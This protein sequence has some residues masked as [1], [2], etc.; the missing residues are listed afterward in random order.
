MKVIFKDKERLLLGKNITLNDEIKFT[1]IDINFNEVDFSK[2][3]NITIFSIFP[4]INTKVCDLQTTSMNKTALL[5]PAFDFIAISLDLPT[6][7]KEWCGSH[8]TENIK[9][10][11]DYRDR[12]FG[13]KTGFLID[14]I[15]LLARGIIVLDKNNKVIYKDVNH[16]VHDQVDFKKLTSFLDNLQN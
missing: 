3:D 13:L 14:E 4:S 5:Y 9:A 15:F 7:L 12:D 6:A 1:L 2:L 8:G 11:S 16:D 10:M